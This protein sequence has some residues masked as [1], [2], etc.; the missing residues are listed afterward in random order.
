VSHG[1]TQQ[2]KLLKL[3]VHIINSTDVYIVLQVCDKVVPLMIKA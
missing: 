1:P 2:D 3:Y